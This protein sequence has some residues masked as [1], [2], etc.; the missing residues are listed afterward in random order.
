MWTI[1]SDESPTKVWTRLTPE[2]IASMGDPPAPKY[3]NNTQLDCD[4]MQ[5]RTKM[6]DRTKSETPRKRRRRHTAPRRAQPNPAPKTQGPKAHEARQA[7]TRHKRKATP[8]SS[9]LKQ[10]LA[11]FCVVVNSL[12]A[13]L[14]QMWTIPSDESP[15]KA[16]V[17]TRLSPES[18]ASMGDPPA[19]KS[20]NSTRLDCDPMQDRTEMKDRTNSETHRKRRRRHTAPR[21]AQPNP[22]PK[23]QGAKAHEARQ[24]TRR[25]KRR[26]TPNSSELK[27]TLAQFCVVVNSLKAKLK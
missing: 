22:A 15:T 14:N 27:Q 24:A 6:K 3:T 18:I 8:K 11:Q 1:P 10:T 26:A 9:E 19:P 16:K 25:H 5:D 7:I 21:R 20:T 4:S 17:W 13:M 23:T 12:K 2:S